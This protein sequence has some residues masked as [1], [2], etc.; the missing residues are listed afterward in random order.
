MSTLTKE[1]RI[2][3]PKAA[4]WE[5]LADLGSIST[6]QPGV[7]ASRSTSEEPGGEGATRHCD[8]VG[9]EQGMEGLLTGLESRVGDGKETAGDGP[10]RG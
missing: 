7:S 9:P 5:V 1:I 6:W 4:V 3:A 2:Q 10:A 8:V